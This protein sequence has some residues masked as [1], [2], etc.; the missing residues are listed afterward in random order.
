MS[1]LWPRLSRPVARTRYEEFGAVTALD[2]VNESDSVH[3]QMSF[4]ATGGTRTSSDRLEGFA[5]TVREVATRFGYP[6]RSGDADRIAFD[7]D[8]AELLYPD[9]D[10]TTFE[11]A[12]PGIWNFMAVVLLPDVTL[13]RFGRTNSERWIASDLTRHMFARLWWQGL[14]FATKRGDDLD[15]ALL[16]Q[17][18]ESDLNQIME[19]RGLAGNP[20]LAQ[21][22]ARA[23]VKAEGARREI[24]REITP[25]LRRRLAFID[26]SALTDDQIDRQIKNLQP[27][28]R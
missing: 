20:R 11:A 10:I 15:F 17:L 4:A 27:T 5:Q 2:L 19:R 24:I 21:A 12:N 9:M 13:W 23:V 7:R 14:T 6:D 22:L 1:E 25:R 8:A 28:A 3:P 26:F 18:S 16:R